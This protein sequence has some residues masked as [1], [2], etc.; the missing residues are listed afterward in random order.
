MFK[1][2]SVVTTIGNIVTNLFSNDIY[3]ASLT[4][5]ERIKL[6]LFKGKLNKWLKEY[7]KEHDGS[8]LTSELFDNYLL[9]HK[10]IEKIFL[11][12]LED[13]NSIG[14]E[15][16]I[17]TELSTFQE[18]AKS[19]RPLSV[20]DNRAFKE[21]L[22][23]IYDRINTFYRGTLSSNQKYIMGFE[24]NLKSQLNTQIQ[25]SENK[26]LNEVANQTGELHKRFDDVC[27]ILAENANSPLDPSV[28][29]KVYEV[30]SRVIM[31]GKIL[32][33]VNILPLVQNKSL[34]CGL[35]FLIHVISND[36]L[37]D[38]SFEMIERDVEDERIYADLIEKTI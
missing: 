35:D 14:I 18:I 2:K 38:Y 9:Y 5:C 21:L 8:I 31:N 11:N 26:I 3:A 33:V 34:K 37:Y 17:N 16:F 10:P 7:I 28:V 12:I 32:E 36:Q 4:L 19:T 6:W 25:K 29:W 13:K 15:E 24:S 20:M 22:S 30:L 1:V 23:G 27:E